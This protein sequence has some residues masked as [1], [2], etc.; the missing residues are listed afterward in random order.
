MP[1]GAAAASEGL[2]LSDSTK[3]LLILLVWLIGGAVWAAGV[4]SWSAVRC[5]YFA[6]AALSTGGLQAVVPTPTPMVP[7]PNQDCPALRGKKGKSTAK[8]KWL[9][10]IPGRRYV[11]NS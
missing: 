9:D 2:Q 4:H 5:V 11:G 6:V 8:T 3:T 7:P 1:W 10:W